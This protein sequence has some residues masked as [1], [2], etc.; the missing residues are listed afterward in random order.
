MKKNDFE[1]RVDDVGAIKILHTC[2]VDNQFE[3]HFT[4]PNDDA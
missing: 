3:Q 1:L 4:N 2:Y